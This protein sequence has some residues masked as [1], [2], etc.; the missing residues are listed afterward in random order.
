MSP[1][2]V[3]PE[4]LGPKKADRINNLSDLVPRE[5]VPPCPQQLWNLSLSKHSIWSA[6]LNKR[7]KGILEQKTTVKFH[8]NHPIVNT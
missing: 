6:V 2:A 4:A 7:K 3:A 5:G 8:L 1:R